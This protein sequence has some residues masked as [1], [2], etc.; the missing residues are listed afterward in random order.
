MRA[1]QLQPLCEALS[2]FGPGPAV[3]VVVVLQDGGGRCPQDITVVPDREADLAERYG[4][5]AP[6][7]GGPPVGYAVVDAAGHIRY[8]TLDPEVAS[9]L[10]EVSTM[11]RAVS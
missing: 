2:G 9:L 5:P 4:L 8:R 1:D 11:L 3:D 7:D 10:G 6:R